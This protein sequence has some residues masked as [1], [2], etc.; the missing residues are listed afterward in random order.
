MVNWGTLQKRSAALQ[1][2][3][4]AVDR[5]GRNN[6]FDDPSELAMIV[7]Q[8]L[9]GYFGLCLRGTVHPNVADTLVRSVRYA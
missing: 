3:E 2:V 9:C 1:L 4:A 6:T 7:Q 8:K 5:W